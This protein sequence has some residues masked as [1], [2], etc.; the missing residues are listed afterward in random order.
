MRL[1]VLGVH[2]AM[3]P[4]ED[5]AWRAALLQYSHG[6]GVSRRDARL[7]KRSALAE[8]L[9]EEWGFSNLTTPTIRKIA[10]LANLDITRAGGQKLE[11]LDNIAKLGNYGKHK[12]NCRRDLVEQIKHKIPCM[13]PAKI[14]IPLL[15]TKGENQGQHLLEAGC[16][17]PHLWMHH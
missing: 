9:L 8:Y 14:K 17:L 1:V 12:Q 6:R 4:G 7:D 11:A 13:Q 5:L 2:L 3:D 16:V 15:I 10:E